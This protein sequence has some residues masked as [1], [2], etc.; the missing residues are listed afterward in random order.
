MSRLVV[1]GILCACAVFGQYRAERVGAPPKEVQGAMAELFDGQGFQIRHNGAA[2]CE[3]W[4][5][6]GNRGSA[7]A[8]TP[9]AK[10][11]VTLP[12]ISEGALE[13]LVHFEEAAEDRLGQSISAGFYTLR[14]A[15]MPSNDDHLGAAAHRDFLLLVPLAEDP[16]PGARVSLEA[17]AELSRRVSH[18]KHPA[19]LSISKSGSET[20]GFSRQGDDWVLETEAD[21]NRV[22]LVVAGTVDR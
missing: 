22:A 3:I 13:G 8:V 20:D 15:V 21:G 5:P 7:G 18:T 17:L 2:Y 12:G 16:G 1:L 9:D 4:L 10:P 6:G 11:G 19:V 14:Y